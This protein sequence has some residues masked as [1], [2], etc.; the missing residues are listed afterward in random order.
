MPER[1]PD[2]RKRL[3]DIGR[4]PGF[5][6]QI[7]QIFADGEKQICVNRRHLRKNSFFYFPKMVGKVFAFSKTV[8][9]EHKH[10]PTGTVARF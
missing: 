9:R 2:V 7:S 5:H 6:P 10:K 8:P 1:F 3:P 4:W